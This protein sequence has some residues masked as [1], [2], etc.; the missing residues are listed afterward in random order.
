MVIHLLWHTHLLYNNGSSDG[1]I[2]LIVEIPGGVL[3][4]DILNSKHVYIMDCHSEVFVWWVPIVGY[5]IVITSHVGLESCQ[6]DW[7]EQLH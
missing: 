1:C 3:K 2:P 5:N 4:S 7:L 6:S